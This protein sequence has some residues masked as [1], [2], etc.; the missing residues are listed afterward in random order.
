MCVC[1]LSDRLSISE[2]LA[3]KDISDLLLR[4]DL[5]LPLWDPETRLIRLLL[6]AD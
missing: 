5:Q 4:R 3:I 6:K 2:L 1:P